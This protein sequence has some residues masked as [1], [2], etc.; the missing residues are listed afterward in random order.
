VQ[1]PSDDD[2][3]LLALEEPVPHVEE[4]VQGCP[5]CH[6]EVQALRAT[7]TTARSAELSVLPAPPALVWDRISRELGIAP[8][9]SASRDHSAGRDDAAADLGRRRRLRH[10]RRTAT[11]ALASAAAAAAFVVIT[12]T[13][14]GPP[15][16]SGPL[17]ALGGA[18]ASGRVVVTEGADKR[19]VLV[20]TEGLPPL[21]QGGYEV[22]LLDPAPDAT[23]L[24]ALGLLDPQGRAWLTLPSGVT[25]ADYPLVDVSIEPDDGNPGHSGDSVLRGDVPA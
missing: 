19:V 18:Q 15:A 6:T 24:V 21:E 13:P 9:H 16:R 8:D 23:R 3:T 4:H 11:A 1:H 14:G 25:L 5:L 2:L 22:W 20:N 7:V 12:L 10:L 17:E